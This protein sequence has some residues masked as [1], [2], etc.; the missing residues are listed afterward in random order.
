MS[1]TLYLPLLMVRRNLRN[2]VGADHLPIIVARSCH[3]PASPGPNRRSPA[4]CFR[5]SLRPS[6]T[7]CGGSLSPVKLAFR[8]QKPLVSSSVCMLQ[9]GQT[10]PTPLDSCATAWPMRRPSLLLSHFPRPLTS[11]LL[12]PSFIA[13]SFS[14]LLPHVKLI[15]GS[16]HCSSVGQISSH[17]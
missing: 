10:P 11:F 15:I 16:S 7:I 1:D 9:L 2:D 13:T 12:L 5:V 17:L 6:E 4:F 3:A 14:S 8:S